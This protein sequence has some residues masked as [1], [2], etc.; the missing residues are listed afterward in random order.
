MLM[1]IIQKMLSK[2]D[3]E[4]DQLYRELVSLEEQY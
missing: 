1:N 4:Y 3:S 2:M